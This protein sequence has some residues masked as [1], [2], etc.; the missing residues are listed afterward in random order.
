MDADKYLSIYNMIIDVQNDQTSK[1]VWTGGAYEAEMFA[2]TSQSFSFSS[3][4]NQP[5][6]VQSAE[7]S[8][9]SG[10]SCG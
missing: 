7:C 8:L 1:R 10:T 9:L 6:Y 5:V 3:K 2:V 4:H